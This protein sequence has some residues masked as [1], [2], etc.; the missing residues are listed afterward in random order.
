[1]L[2]LSVETSNINKGGLKWICALKISVVTIATPA[3]Q[4]KYMTR[5]RKEMKGKNKLG[6]KEINEEENGDFFI[7][8]I[9]KLT[10]I[11]AKAFERLLNEHQEEDIFCWTVSLFP[12]ATGNTR[13][14]VPMTLS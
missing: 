2:T 8:F 12:V 11:Y 4:G 14:Y 7:D 1:M 5:E 6:N 10:H 13:S 3:G 9:L